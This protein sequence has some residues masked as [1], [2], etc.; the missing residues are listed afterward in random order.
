MTAKKLVGCLLLMEL[1]AGLAGCEQDAVR[2]VRNGEACSAADSFRA[3]VTFCRRVSRRS[4][5]RLGVG[6]EFRIAEKS[7]V[8]AFVDFA[9]VQPQRTHSVHL[10]WIRPDGQELFRKYAEISLAPLEKGYKARVCWLDAEDHVYRREEEQTAAGPIFS[11]D[12]SLDISA[13]R[14]RDPGE[15]RL[16]IYWNRELLLEEP[17]T[18]L[19][20]S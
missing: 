16:R 4:G 12:S 3:E 10:V 20:A 19:T 1:L 7:Y 14:S 9:G 11:L 15:Y 18:V 5:Q 6:H 8:R 2:R 13:D 17:F